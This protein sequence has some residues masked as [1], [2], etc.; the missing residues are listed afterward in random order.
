MNENKINRQLIFQID[1]KQIVTAF[2][3]QTMRVLVLLV[4]NKLTQLSR[5]VPLLNK[6]IRLVKQEFKQ[7]EK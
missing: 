3:H 2:Q 7:M 1:N 6:K 5:Q 4:N